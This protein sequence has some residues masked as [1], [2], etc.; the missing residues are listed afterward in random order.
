MR[1][2]GPKRPQNTGPQDREPLVDPDFAAL[3]FDT[4]VDLDIARSLNELVAARG[5]SLEIYMHELFAARQ[6]A[7]G[8]PLSPK[9][10]E[11]IATHDPKMTRADRK[12]F[13]LDLN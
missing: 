3:F 6:R 5:I 7:E 13:G 12:T 4:L 11:Y 10:R 1:K 8:K 2:T 9:L